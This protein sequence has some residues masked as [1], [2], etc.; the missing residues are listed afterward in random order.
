MPLDTKPSLTLKRH[1]K[2]SPE[3]VFEAWTQA[4]QLSRWF[5]PGSIAVCE[6]ETDLKVGGRYRIAMKSPDDE[7]HRVGGSYREI[8]HG[9]RLVFTWAW[10]STPERESV[11]TLSLKL[12]DG[13]TDLTL[14]HEQFFDAAARDRHEGGWS[15]ALEKL[16][17]ILEAE[18]EAGVAKG[19]TDGDGR[20]WHHGHVHWSE[21]MTRDPEAARAFYAA[22]LGWDFEAMDMPNGTYWIA[23]NEVGV[24]GGIF[25]I[26]DTPCEEARDQWLTYVAVDDVD[27]RAAKAV[28]AGAEIMRPVF[29]IPGVGRIVMLREPGGADVGWITP[30]D[31]IPKS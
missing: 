13:G 11:V 28:K 27:T 10:Q 1:I 7:E 2:A 19:G 16:S 22:S 3:K 30:A 4:E 23:R 20:S 8:V 26:S 21:L 6:A 17:A 14:Q 5:G 18:D 25:D 12:R 15:G 9:R 31:S 24:I 29:D